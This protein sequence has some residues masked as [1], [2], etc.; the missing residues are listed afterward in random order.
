MTLDAGVSSDHRA[1]RSTGCS[2]LL[3]HNS[4]E[5]SYA[6]VPALRCIGDPRPHRGKCG[7]HGTHHDQSDAIIPP[8]PGADVTTV[9]G[10]KASLHLFEAEDISSSRSW[11]T[12]WVP[13]PAHSWH[14]CWPR[15]SPRCPR[16]LWVSS[17]WQAG[18]PMSSCFPHHIWFDV[19]DLVFAYLPA[20]WLG[21]MT[22]W[23]SGSTDCRTRHETRS[24]PGRRGMRGERSRTHE[25]PIPE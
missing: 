22:R 10:L 1:F 23:P 14:G 16:T 6:Q 24:S 21:Q 3:L 5:S 20:A 12:H 15:A 11:P 18:S 17:S 7:Q 4:T 2:H 9:E 13:W 8:P 25:R 19:V